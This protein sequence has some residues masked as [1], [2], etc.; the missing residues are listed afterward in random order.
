M[1]TVESIC[2]DIN[3]YTKS[4]Y[5]RSVEIYIGTFNK[6]GGSF[7]MDSKI[8]LA[9]EKKLLKKIKQGNKKYNENNKIYRFND[10]YMVINS[11]GHKKYTSKRTESSKLY[12]CMYMEINNQCNINEERFPISEK[13]HDI[14]NQSV[15][16]YIYGKNNQVIVSFIEETCPTTNNT[17]NYVKINYKLN[18]DNVNF[19][20]DV[21]FNLSK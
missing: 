1:D 16:K 3:E 2:E 11:K 17:I 7:C 6:F 18:S 5:N 20:K 9:I 15:R 10:M 21:L 19:L 4:Y 13:Y 8:L 12:D 14:V